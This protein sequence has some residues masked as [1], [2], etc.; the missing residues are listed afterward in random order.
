MI[1]NS[2]S[3]IISASTIGFSVLGDFGNFRIVIASILLEIS[4]V[5]SRTVQNSEYQDQGH[6]LDRQ[7][8]GE[9]DQNKDKFL[10]FLSIRG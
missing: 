10:L 8:A 5:G 7:G 9:Q 6:D 1:V 4:S 2:L 3:V